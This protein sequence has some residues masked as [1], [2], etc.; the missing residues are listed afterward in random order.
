MKIRF[1]TSVAG[2]RFAYRNKQ[3]VDL[4]PDLAEEFIR[5]GQ[6]VKVEDDP[7]PGGLRKVLR[8][9]GKSGEAA[10]GAKR[11]VRG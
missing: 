7:L 9:G 10:A 8:R 11:E 2:A 5:C 1:T 3:V 4:R 6:A